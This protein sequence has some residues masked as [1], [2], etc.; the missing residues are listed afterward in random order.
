MRFL[1]SAI[2]AA[3]MFGALQ[4]QAGILFEP[5]AGYTMGDLKLVNTSDVASSGSIDGFGYGGKLSWTFSNYYFGGEYQAARARQK[6]NN[7]ESLND[8][9]NTSI[10]G[11]IGIQ[12]DMGFRISAGMTVSPHRSEQAGNPDK[13]IYTGS[14]KKV[15]IGYRYRAPLAINIDY[16]MYEFDKFKEG[17][18]EGK[19]KERF[20]KM[21]YSAFMLSISFPFE[22]G[23]R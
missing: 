14:A 3:L 15:S 8:W 22:V 6:M 20:D 12:F 4:T 16:I 18:A 10:F 9:S 1:K 13:T 7:S 23:E 19:V 21:D 11:V 5:Y 2:V 17:T